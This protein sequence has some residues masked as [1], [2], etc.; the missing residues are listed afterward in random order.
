MVGK[1]GRSRDLKGEMYVTPW[2]DFPDRFLDLKEIYLD[3]NGTWRLMKVQSSRL[4]SGRPVLKFKGINTPEAANRLTNRHLAVTSDQLVKL[5]EGTYYVFDLIG[6]EVFDEAGVKI[7]EVTDVQQYPAND[8]YVIRT[9]DNEEVLFPAVTE[10]VKEVDAK[11]RKI[12]VRNA[13]LCEKTK[14][15]RDNEV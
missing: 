5:P 3:E 2:T 12:I 7:G 10:F 11:N 14:D 9:I 1:L 15:K 4:V 13:G 6:C 8:A